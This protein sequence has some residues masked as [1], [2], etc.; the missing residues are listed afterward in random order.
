MSYL[1]A[2]L[3]LATVMVVPT[4][5]AFEFQFV[6]LAVVLVVLLTCPGIALLGTISFAATAEAFILFVALSMGLTTLAATV[7]VLLGLWPLEAAFW[8]LVLVSVVGSGVQL[9]RV[10]Y[11]GDPRAYP[12]SE[13]R[14]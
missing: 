1:V 9:L 7:T 10:R 5:L 11:R 14:V 13:T 8:F 3:G 4:L 2:S 12:T 6:R